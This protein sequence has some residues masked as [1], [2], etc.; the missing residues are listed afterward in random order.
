MNIIKKSKLFMIVPLLVMAIAFAPFVSF[1][2]ENGKH[3][4]EG[5]KVKVKTEE[6]DNQGQDE[7]KS[8]VD[9]LGGIFNLFGNHNQAEAVSASTS[10]SASLVPS[11]SGIT[12]PTVLKT[13][14]TGTWSVRAS[15]PQNG[16]LSYSVDW[17]ESSQG[18]TALL[19]PISSQTSTFTHSYA[20]PGVYT[21]KFTVSNSAGDTVSTVT[22]HVVGATAQAPIIRNLSVK[23]K[24]TGATFRWHTDTPAT[25]LV[26]YST[27][28]PVSTSVAPN[29]TLSSHIRQHKLPLTGLQPNTKYYAVVGS[30]NDTGTTMSSEISFTT[31]ADN[32]VPV[33]TSLTGSSTVVAG[34][35]ETV[36]INAFDPNNDTLSYSADWGDTASTLRAASLNTETPFVQTATFTHIYTQ[37]GVYTAT[38]TAEN[39]SGK[40]T[41]SS[42]SITV[43]PAVVADTTAPVIASHDNITVDATSNA[44]AVVTY[45]APVATDNVDAT[46]TVTCLPA[47][48]S[49]FAIGQTKVLCDAT[50]SSG[51]KAV[52]TSFTVTVNDVISPVISNVQVV[53][54]NSSQVKISW[55]TDEAANGEVFYSQTT[56]VDVNTS[57][58]VS[59]ASL[60]TDHLFEISGL[61]ANT[62]YHFLIESS[63]VGGKT[64]ATTESSFTT[65]P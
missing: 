3:H 9:L 45:T 65:N 10:T 47:S 13:G 21:V 14:Q 31:K 62:T 30:A 22:V 40:K 49:T 46:V 28:S 26:W 18:L 58:S 19:T 64:S 1:A 61:T 39:S 32:T 52:Q 4:D 51:N 56:P 2:K 48:G 55:H 6:R 60:V 57:A 59:N 35:T 50:D 53:V 5:G 25:G 11:I 33:I 23:P 8:S 38:F 44:G 15:D 7:D 42:M 12:A 37:A 20:N 29:V 43:T 54:E 16:S 63:D 34:Q 41:S 24:I 27:T 36:T 17:G